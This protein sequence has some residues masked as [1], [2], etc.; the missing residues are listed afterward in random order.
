MKL[1]VIGRGLWGSAAAR[2]LARA[3][4]DITLI[5]PSEPQDKRRHRGVFG[6]HY[7]EGRLTRKNALDPYWVGVSIAA[8]ERY[9]E[10]EAQSGIKFYTE[11]G[12]MMAGGAE[13]MAKIEPGRIA[14]NVEC[15]MLDHDSLR[16]QFDFFDFPAHFTASYEPH[17]AGHISPRR[18]VAAQTKAA[19][20]AGAKLIEA[21]VT[22]LD[23]QAGRV[24]VST[25][26]GTMTFDRVLVAAGYNSDTVLGREPCM[27]VYARTVA[28][29]EVGAAEVSRLA[30]M[31]TLVYDAPE[32]PYLVPPIRYPDGKSY[33][34]LG[35]DPEDVPL[36]SA[37]DI[38]DW[39]RGGGA[40][41]VR[42]HL[43]EM[44][45]SLMPQFDIQSV[46]MEACVTTW[47]H[48]RRPELCHISDRIALCGGGNGAGAKCSDEIGR[49][50]AAL[51]SDL[52]A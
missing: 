26:K 46:S 49:Q 42:D 50:G 9:G 3:G 24:Q 52:V 12:A 30:A 15:E 35:G 32:D 27:D 5:G 40:P 34:K 31:P 37:G 44:I 22:G 21:T 17:M 28:F 16:A 48:D 4:E 43:H 25:D 29:F 38:E 41:D 8:I 19:E 14:H 39:F 2:H 10:I 7:D 23:E 18:L 20:T 1:A 11:T 36:T 13:F 33:I 47:T 6:S 45:M 51:I